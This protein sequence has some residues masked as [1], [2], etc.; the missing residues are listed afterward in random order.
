VL[1]KLAP[2]NVDDEP[3]HL[4]DFF[5][6]VCSVIH[7]DSPFTFE[8]LFQNETIENSVDTK[9]VN[10]KR[11]SILSIE[12]VSYKHTGSYTCKVRNKAGASYL[13]AALVVEGLSKPVKLVLSLVFPSM[14]LS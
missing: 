14:L 13:T 3:L 7:G 1:P 6:I 9:I 10:S 12:S 4:D 11:T 8:W 2:F 5:Q